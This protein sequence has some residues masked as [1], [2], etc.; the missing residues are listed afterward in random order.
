MAEQKRAAFKRGDAVMYYGATGPKR[1]WW[2]AKMYAYRILASDPA[3]LDAGLTI[4][5][6]EVGRTVFPAPNEHGVYVADD[7]TFTTIEYRNQ[8]SYVRVAYLQVGPEQWVARYSFDYGIYG[9]CSPAHID[10]AHPTWM[11]A[12]RRPLT[13]IISALARAAATDSSW[14]TRRFAKD[15]MLGLLAQVP[16]SLQTTIINEVKSGRTGK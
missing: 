7:A 13:H 1:M 14:A 15:A 4:K 3:N 11:D 2:G 16:A 12:I 8:R 5:E 9:G 6:E 10:D